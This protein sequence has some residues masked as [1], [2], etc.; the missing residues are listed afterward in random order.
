M[1]SVS[2]Q[3]ED[4]PWCTPLKLRAKSPW[5]RR[6]TCEKAQEGFNQYFIL[7]VKTQWGITIRKLF[8][9]P[10]CRKLFIVISFVCRIGVFVQI[11]T[12]RICA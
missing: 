11:F 5:V 10:I 1:Q 2:H 7:C 3:I 12:E 8:C 6:L 4:L 9:Y